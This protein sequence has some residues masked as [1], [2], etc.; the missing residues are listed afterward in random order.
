[1]LRSRVAAFQVGSVTEK[2]SSVLLCANRMKQLQRVPGVL[3]SLDPAYLK[4]TELYVKSVGEIIAKAQITNGGPI[5]LVQP[6]NE[7]Y[8]CLS[9]VIPCPNPTYMKYVED[10]LR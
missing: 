2:P 1:M 5:V 3:R 7:Y 6:E 8:D 10:Q 4:A 9:S